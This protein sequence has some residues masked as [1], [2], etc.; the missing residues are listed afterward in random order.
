[1]CKMKNFVLLFI[2]LGLLLVA[3][4]CGGIGADGDRVTILVGAAASLTDA[5]SEIEPLFEKA[6]GIDLDLQFSATGPL[7]E[8]IKSGADIDVFM[9]A[10]KKD[11]DEMVV[12]GFVVDDEVLLT[13]E[14]ILAKTKGRDVGSIDDLKSVKYIA[15]GEPASVPVGKYAV[16]AITNLGLYDS[17][18]SKFT[19]A[20]D[21]SQVLNW[22][23]LGNAEVGFVYYSDFVRSGGKVELVEKVD[24]SKYASIVYPMGLVKAS[25][26]VDEARSF[27]EFLKGDEAKAVFKKYGF[28]IAE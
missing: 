13:N 2:G 19:Y 22:V 6:E 9:S 4:G 8:Q 20:K 17:L 1:M 11:M 16:E 26:K 7:K 24:S 21:V 12:A 25:T 10:S 5:I 3:S 14:L 15:I 28:G 18:K 23:E 27:M